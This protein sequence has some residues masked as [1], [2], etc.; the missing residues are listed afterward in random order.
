VLEGQQSARVAEA[1]LAG[2]DAG[3]HGGRQAQQ[4]EEVGH[5][6]AVLAGAR[7]HLLLGHVELAG[8]PLE[9]ARLLH[10]VQV[11]ALQVF[12]DGDLH[13]LLV[14]DLAQD[15]RNGLFAGQLRG[16]PAALAGDELEAAA[17]Q[18][19]TRMGCTTPLATMEAAS[20]A[21]CSSFTWER[22]WKGLRS[23]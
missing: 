17:G 10:G 11:G 12:D 20:S 18:R 8:E 16:A 1:E 7:G 14:G 6:G 5:R 9:G 2:L 13:R 4:A 21:N 22:V 15:G 19:R 23:I 3:L